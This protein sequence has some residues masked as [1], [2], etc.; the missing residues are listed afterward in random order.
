MLLHGSAEC[1][2]EGLNDARVVRSWSVV[3][4]K[5]LTAVASPRHYW[6]FYA[7]DTEAVDN[8]VF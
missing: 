6:G 5:G 3:Q 8:K 2:T 4:S 1:V 7:V